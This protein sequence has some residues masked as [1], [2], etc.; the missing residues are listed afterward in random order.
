MTVPHCNCDT[1]C[2]QSCQYFRPHAVHPFNVIPKLKIFKLKN[3]LEI[4]F[5]ATVDRTSDNEK[6]N[7]QAANERSKKEGEKN[8]QKRNEKSKEET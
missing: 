3:I 5:L 1:V 8:V 7:E 2:L 4:F 6:L